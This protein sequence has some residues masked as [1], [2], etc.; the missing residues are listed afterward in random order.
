MSK[1]KNG[2]KN[3]GQ[4]N[5]LLKKI[6]KIHVNSINKK[7]KQLNSK[8]HMSQNKPSLKI[9]IFQTLMEM[10]IAKPNNIHQNKRY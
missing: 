5:N 4:N 7:N 9:R 6:I 3:N 1:K 8:L 10:Q 2:I